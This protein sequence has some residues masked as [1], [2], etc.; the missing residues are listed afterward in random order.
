[1]LTIRTLETENRRCG[2]V[3]DEQ[4]PR[5]HFSLDS[6]QNGTALKTA[7]FQLGE[8]TCHTEDFSVVYDGPPLSPR[9][10]YAVS[11]SAIDN[12]GETAEASMTF[13]TGKL[14]EP[15]SGLWITHGAYRFRE[16]KVSPKPMC[17]RKLFKLDGEILHARLYCTA[18]G[19]YRCC[20]NGREIG[21]DFLTPGFTSYHNQ[22]QYQAYDVSE[23]LKDENT[24]STT[25]SGGWAVGSYTYYRR[26][27]VY[28]KRQA[29]LAELHLTYRDGHEQ[30]ISTD[31]TWETT[32]DGPLKA[33]D[34]YDGEIYDA[35][36]Q[37]ECWVNASVEKLRFKPK[38]IAD[39]GE[40]VRV[41]ER[42]DPVSV[43]A[44]ASGETIYDFGQNFAG[45]VEIRIRGTP[46][47]T[48]KLRHAEVLMN[49]ELF[50]E[51]LRSAKQE[52]IYTCRGGGEET[53]TPRFSY[54]GFRY[55]G[56]TGVQPENIT[57]TALGL[58][59]NT[60]VTGSFTCSN[61]LLNRLEKNVYY[62]ARS[63]FMDIPTDCPQRDE[64]LGWTGDIALFASTASCHF[65][66]SRFFDKWLRDLQSEQGRGGGLPMIVPSV[67]IYNQIEMCIPHAVD[68]WGDACILIPWAE[69]LAR[70]D[71]RILKRNY[72]MMRRYFKACLWW[73][74]LFSRGEDRY[75]WQ[76]FHHYGDWCAPDTDFK[77]W[78]ARGQWT[79]TACLSHS[80]GLLSKIAELLGEETDTR[81]YSEISQKA[82][83][84][85]RSRFLSGDLRLRTEFQTAYVLPLY[86]E[87][88][89]GREREAMAGYLAEL[90]KTQGICTGFP[91]TPYL[92]F[93]LMDNG[94]PETA[95]ETLLSEKCPSWLYEVKAGG[96]T[97][98]ERWDALR[99]DG[100]CNQGDGAGM[101]SFNH[102]AP[103]AVSDFLYR[104]IAGIESKGGG[105]RM[106][107]IEPKP[108]GGLVFA[109]GEV[110]T[111]FGQIVSRW[112]V[113][114]NIFKINVVVPVGTQCELVLPNAEVKTL[115]SGN[116]HFECVMDG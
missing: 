79:A 92:L 7:C 88:L 45:V 50:T 20:L 66:M 53:Y 77:G 74:G 108:G 67:K 44:A 2:L 15:W 69:Y 31:D 38:L 9:T 60:A 114:N 76:M 81:M 52:L 87:L 101:V 103:G 19:I 16:K 93:A 59:S 68:H 56:V 94:Q 42:R 30:V 40:P 12:R 46:G 27:R 96:T 22:I 89:P 95:Y 35:R 13:E 83:D 37:N 107:R 116:Y 33:A 106:F 112:I 58:S 104:R 1:M 78:M 24:L 32:M 100:T 63:N 111:P 36:T 39:Y 115:Q 3:T 4:Q 73:A 5:F 99:E 6:D 17:F 86:Y 41:Y 25:V 84:A 48:V 57:L 110:E 71:I 113:D 47:Q 11:V 90:V 55:V 64:R 97:F 29:F 10:K 62:G 102:F 109:K 98:W 43:S 28:A 65:N 14:S 72:P 23:L 61:E 49:G 75:I 70:G 21:E 82:A 18:L 105:Y 51:P 34:L 54:M 26:N 8:W 85:Y 91:G 80:A